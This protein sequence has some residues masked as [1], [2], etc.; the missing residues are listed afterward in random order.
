MAEEIEQHELEGRQDHQRKEQQGGPAGTTPQRQQQPDDRTGQDDIGDIG[1]QTHALGEAQRHIGQE[2]YG[3]RKPEDAARR[4]AAMYETSYLTHSINT[5]SL[6]LYKYRRPS[7][8]HRH[9]R[10]RLPEGREDAG[11]PSPPQTE[12]RRPR[13]RTGGDERLPSKID[14]LLLHREIRTPR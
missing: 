13:H 1:Q 6:S 3:K 12:T 11:R 8:G 9:H 7:P 2:E 5:V 4:G 10:R 14:N